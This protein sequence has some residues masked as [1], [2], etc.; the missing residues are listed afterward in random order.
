MLLIFEDHD[1]LADFSSN[2]KKLI[3]LEVVE[4][5]SLRYIEALHSDDS[6]PSQPAGKAKQTSL[7]V[8]LDPFP[9]AGIALW[10]LPTWKHV[11][12]TAHSIAPVFSLSL[13]SLNSI[14]NAT[15]IY[16]L[17]LK[18]SQSRP[19]G[20]PDSNLEEFISVKLTFNPFVSYQLLFSLFCWIFRNY[21]NRAREVMLKIR[22]LPRD[23]LN[24]VNLL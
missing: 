23:T 6:V 15:K 7:P 22:N 2:S 5:L 12:W 11:K 18:N 21:L 4:A 19:V 1:I 3:A 16:C 14:S 10:K 13:E 9:S 20:V 8:I 17:W 24:S